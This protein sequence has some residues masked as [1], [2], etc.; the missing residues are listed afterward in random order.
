MSNIFSAG[1]HYFQK[2]QFLLEELA[3]RDFK[4]KYKRTI[5]GV[6]WSLLSPL[7]MLSV[8]AIIFGQFFGSS[9]PHYIIYLFSGQIVF[10]YFVESTNEG[11]GAL[12]HNGEI[13][14]KINLPKY[15]LIISKNTSAFINFLAIL[16]VY[17]IFVLIDNIDI[18]FRF[19]LLLYPIIMMIIM[20][21]GISFLLSTM[22]V[23]FRDIQ[24]LYRIFTQIVMYGSAIFYTISTMSSHAQMVFY[25]NPIYLI[26]TYFR[27][28][29]IDG[30]IP[31]TTLHLAILGYSFVLFILGVIVYNRLKNKFIYY[32]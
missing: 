32:L 23:F 9:I 4:R 8:M 10:N 11:M 13:L 2:N 21:V 30:Y 24:Y 18:S 15:L 22:F 12:V 28:I 1:I 27:T 20:N 26:I 14:K 7:F 19:L 16:I 5:L 6:F 29:V 25:F 17:F 31:D 3:K